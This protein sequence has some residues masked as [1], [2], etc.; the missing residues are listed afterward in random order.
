MAR[1]ALRVPK[2]LPQLLLTITKV[3]HVSPNCS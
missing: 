3:F 2:L 1:E